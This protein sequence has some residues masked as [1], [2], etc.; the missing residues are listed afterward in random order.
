MDALERRIADAQRQLARDRWRLHVGVYRLYCDQIAEALALF[1]RAR[2]AIEDIDLLA[3]PD[4]RALENAQRRLRAAAI[5]RQLTYPREALRALHDL[6]KRLVTLGRHAAEMRQ[7]AVRAEDLA[8]P[9]NAAAAASG[10]L[11]LFERATTQLNDAF[12]LPEL[13]S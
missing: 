11:M 1:D 9:R 3:G 10:G 12:T 13:A 5:G 2:D 8:A 6:L 4:A 7:R